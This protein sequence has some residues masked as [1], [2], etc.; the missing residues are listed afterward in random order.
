MQ[1]AI[2][3]VSKDLEECSMVHGAS[4]LQTM[5]RI[6]FPLLRI[7]IAGA[8]VIVFALSARSLTIPLLLYSYGTETLTISLLYYYEEGHRNI[9]AVIAVIQLALVMALLV[10]EKLT[11][12]RSAE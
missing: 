7:G 6:V 12:P 8:F 2:M 5:A 1:S 11:R 10:L 9:T 3:Q 4:W